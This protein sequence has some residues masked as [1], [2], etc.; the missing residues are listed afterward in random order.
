[1]EFFFVFCLFLGRLWTQKL[2]NE[3]AVYFTIYFATYV[4]LFAYVSLSAGQKVLSC[5]PTERWLT[6]WHVN[7]IAGIAHVNVLPAHAP[8][9]LKQI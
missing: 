4:P 6:G 2:E 8:L 7:D 1:M 5:R 9:I 3:N